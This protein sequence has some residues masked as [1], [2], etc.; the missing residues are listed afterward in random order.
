MPGLRVFVS[1]WLN[2]LRGSRG[3]AENAEQTQ[4]FSP[5]SH[6]DTE[7]CEFSILESRFSIFGPSPKTPRGYSE[8]IRSRYFSPPSQRDTE[9]IQ[10]IGVGSKPKAFLT[11]K[12]RSTQSQSTRRMASGAPTDARTASERCDPRVR[13]LPA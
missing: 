12:A 13:G 6:R 10:F 3:G 5:P 4:A 9:S 1:S 11:T 8:E 7:S 2:G